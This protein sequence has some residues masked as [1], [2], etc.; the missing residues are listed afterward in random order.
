[1]DTSRR[2][3]LETLHV[4]FHA[5]GSE[6]SGRQ[7][8][9]IPFQIFLSLYDRVR[10]TAALIIKVPKTG[11][12]GLKVSALTFTPQE[13]GSSN[14]SR[15]SDLGNQRFRSLNETGQKWLTDGWLD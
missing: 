7:S 15:G 14:L 10:A 12:S 5:G 8:L 9:I 4:D 13:G 3:L 6:K 11:Y 2:T 1:M